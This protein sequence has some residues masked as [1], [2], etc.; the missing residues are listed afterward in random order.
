MLG[1]LLWGAPPPAASSHL[2]LLSSNLPSM[3]HGKLDFRYLHRE[4]SADVCTGKASASPHCGLTVTSAH[5][6]LREAH[7]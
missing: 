2:E 7:Q 1:T 5:Q 4:L 6:R 3:F